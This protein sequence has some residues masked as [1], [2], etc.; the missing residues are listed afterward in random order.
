ML[1]SSF[2]KTVAEKANFTQG[3]VRL[4]LDAVEEV[5]GDIIRDSDNVKLF[6]GLYVE[7]VRV[8]DRETTNYFT[9]E[10]LHV[11]EHIIPRARF[12]NNFK[13]KLRQ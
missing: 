7:G 2:I 5:V 13:Y 4:V 10:P 1:R 12:T 6:E 8:A 3:D 9:G 11:P